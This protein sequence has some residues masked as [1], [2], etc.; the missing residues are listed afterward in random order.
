MDDLNISN[1]I[2]IA[3]E[4]FLQVVMVLARILMGS[5]IVAFGLTVIGI[6]WQCFE[7]DRQVLPR[8]VRTSEA[9]HAARKT[10]PFPVKLGIKPHPGS[11]VSPALRR[12][13]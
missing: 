8:K 13:A 3:S 2:A 5:A 6:I 11:M 12:R 1:H 4:A 9:S 7:Q 10:V